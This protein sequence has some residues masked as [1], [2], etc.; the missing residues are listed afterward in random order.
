MTCDEVRV[1]IPQQ[2]ERMLSDKI[3][4]ELDSHIQSCPDCKAILEAYRS[5]HNRLVT[6]GQGFYTVP[7]S[8]DKDV[9][10]KI[11]QSLKGQPTGL[12]GKLKRV[13]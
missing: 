6:W 9:M 2:L 12:S 7:G 11:D 1:L 8:F 4:H 10:T 3:Q 5:V 13:A